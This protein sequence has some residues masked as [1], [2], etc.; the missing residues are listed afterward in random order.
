[1]CGRFIL[2]ADAGTLQLKFD[3]QTAPQNVTA[4]YNIAPSQPIMAISND[5]PTQATYYQWGLIPSWS[6]DPKIGYKMINARSETA[7]E[8]PAFRA[9]FSR[10]RCLIP[11]NGF[12]EWT[13]NGKQKTPM[14]VHMDDLELF[15]LAGLWEV[16]HSPEG[17]EVRTCTILTTE[18]NEVVKPL[19]NRMAVILHEEDY[20][21]WLSPDERPAK[22]LKPLLRPYEADRMDAYAVSTIVNSPQNDTPEC[23]QPVEAGPEQQTLL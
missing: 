16:W 7:H 23:I 14:L 12:Y 19:H 9:A 4:R 21:T 15:A 11:A 3:L 22:E 1:M 18:P 20:E 5:D 8:K 13:K 6:K 17:E 2:T 10:R